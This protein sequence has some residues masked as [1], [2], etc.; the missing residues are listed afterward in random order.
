MNSVDPPLHQGHARRWLGLCV[1]CAA[2]FIS[3]VDTTIVNVALPAIADDLG[4]TF[5]DLQWVI[6]GFLVIL[7]GTLLIGSGLADRFGR[8][9]IFVISLLAF[10]LTSMLAVLATN[11]TQLILARV[12]MGAAAAGLLPT[13]LSLLAVMFAP[14]ERAKAV[15]IWT[16]VAGIGVGFGP[17]IGSILLELSGWQAVFLI[18]VPVCL[19]AAV[20]AIAILP[21]S[22]RPGVPPMDLLG[23]AASIVALG[24]IVFALIEGGSHGFGQMSVLVALGLGIAA[25]AAFVALE[26]RRQSPLFDVRILRRAPVFSGAVA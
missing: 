2:T 24:G 25:T 19:A 6:D 5:S 20:F 14:S 18:N 26:L 21:E 12:L 10:A 8:K 4:A 23:A 17:L 9:R 3:G 11:P 1:I 7:A 22:R 16:A 13:A 15:G